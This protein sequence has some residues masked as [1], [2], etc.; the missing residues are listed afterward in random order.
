[1]CLGTGFHKTT[2]DLQMS[3]HALE[4]DFYVLE[5]KLDVL[6]IGLHVVESTPLA[7]ERPL[8][9]HKQQKPD[10]EW[11]GFLVTRPANESSAPQIEL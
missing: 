11:S 1:M 8:T 9:H 6:E 4:I 10:H 7:P 3:L 5:M 2:S